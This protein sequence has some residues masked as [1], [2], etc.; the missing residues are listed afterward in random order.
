[1][2]DITK[3]RELIQR[4]ASEGWTEL[5]LSSNEL[6]KVPAEVT[7]LRNLTSLNL[8]QNQLTNLLPDIFRMLFEDCRREIVLSHGVRVGLEPLRLFARLSS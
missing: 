5:D 2:A 6:T 8:C 3:T 4:A 7:K 1:M